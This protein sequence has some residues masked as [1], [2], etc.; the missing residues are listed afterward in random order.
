MVAKDAEQAKYALK[1][2]TELSETVKKII[3][4]KGIIKM[5]GSNAAKLLK[6]MKAIESVIK[7]EKLEQK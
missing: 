6:P 2:N 3:F 5:F 7:D 4:R 1:T